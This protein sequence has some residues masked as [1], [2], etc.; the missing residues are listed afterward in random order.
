MVFC[1]IQI[2]NNEIIDL[3]ID[4]FPKGKQ[5]NADYYSSHYINN[6]VHSQVDSCWQQDQNYFKIAF[7][8]VFRDSKSGGTYLQQ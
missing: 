6:A 4:C 8:V 1:T 5:N 3:F 7:L 2:R